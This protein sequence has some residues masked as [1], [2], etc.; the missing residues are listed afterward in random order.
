MDKV[1]NILFVGVGGQGTIL[2]SNILTNGL[3]NAGY[4]VK[5]SEVH[6]MAQRGG[7]VSTQIR[8]GEKVYSPL[9]S[10][11]EADIILAFEKIEAARWLN[12]LSEEGLLIINNHEIYPISVLAGQEEYPKDILDKIKE[13]IKKCIIVD[14]NS[15][16]LEIG[17][18][19]VQN[20]ILLGVLIGSLK[21]DNINWEEI[22][23][24][25]IP[26]KIRE[27]NLKAFNIGLNLS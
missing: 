10:E 5:M 2:A 15:K 22:I 17:N 18:S 20:M 11:G 27:I 19:K 13:K 3:I 21:L 24:N 4:D 7:S 1:T 26:E 12:F 25:N 6:G 16:A 14:A 23:K 8:F 9:I